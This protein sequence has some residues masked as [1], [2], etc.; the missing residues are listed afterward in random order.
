MGDRGAVVFTV[1]FSEPV[2][3][4]YSNDD[5]VTVSTFSRTRSTWVVAHQA[6]ELNYSEVEFTR[7]G[8]AAEI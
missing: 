3:R 1:L 7:D 8:K 2:V 4:D 5:A 6:H